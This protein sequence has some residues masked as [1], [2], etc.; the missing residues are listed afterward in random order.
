MESVWYHNSHDN[1]TSSINVYCCAFGVRVWT[2]G[3]KTDAIE[4][5]ALVDD[6]FSLYGKKT[7]RVHK[8][9]STCGQG[10]TGYATLLVSTSTYD[11]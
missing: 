1:Q 6:T 7:L 8:C 5:A 11:F 3:V 2:T 4:N 10:Q 9:P